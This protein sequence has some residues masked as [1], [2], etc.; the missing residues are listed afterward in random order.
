MKVEVQVM[1]TEDYNSNGSRYTSS[2]VKKDQ[3]GG[4]AK[5]EDKSGK[6]NWNKFDTFSDKLKKQ[7]L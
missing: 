3:I 6:H 5:E 7:L 4:D 2:T 1:T